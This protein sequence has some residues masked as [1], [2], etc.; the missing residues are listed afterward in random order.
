MLT[1]LFSICMIGHNGQL[2]PFPPRACIA[3]RL[4]GKYNRDSEGSILLLQWLTF[5]MAISSLENCKHFFKVSQEKLKRVIFMG[6]VGG[7]LVMHLPL[8]TDAQAAKKGSAKGPAA[9][10]G[11]LLKG[12]ITAIHSAH[13]DVTLQSGQKGRVCL[14]EVQDAE[15]ALTQGGKPFEG[16]SQGQ[17][18]EAVCLGQ[19]EGF[20]GRKM[21]L[22]DLSVRAAVLTAAAN[23]SNVTSLRLRVSKL[24]LGQTVYGCVLYLPCPVLPCPALPCQ[25]CA[26]ELCCALLC[27]CLLNSNQL[28]PPVLLIKQEVRLGR[29]QHFT[30]VLVDINAEF[31]FLTIMQ[32]SILP[33]S[34]DSQLNPAATSS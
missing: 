4:Y 29:K 12:K 28:C 22:L 13:M 6:A 5:M 10:P 3:R 25:T 17:N 26:A 9:H 23:N 33:L 34:G 21:G 20:E 24:K 2:Q 15:L 32:N 19:M 7:R 31:R 11:Q 14:C 8:L 18:V 27:H 16:F 1:S 30:I